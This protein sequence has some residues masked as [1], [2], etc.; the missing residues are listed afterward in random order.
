MKEATTPKI[1]RINHQIAMPLMVLSD[2]AIDLTHFNFRFEVTLAT[3][4]ST[5]FCGKLIRKTTKRASRGFTG[6][7]FF[8]HRHRI[9]FFFYS[10]M[11]QP[12][13]QYNGASR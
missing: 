6:G 13:S 3:R 11:G 10:L 8:D 2:A 1:D 9:D 7:F 12:A 5:L 4:V